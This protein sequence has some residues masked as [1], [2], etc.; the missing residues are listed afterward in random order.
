MTLLAR[1]KQKGS[2]KALL[3]ELAVIA[4]ITTLSQPL[5]VWYSSTEPSNV[6]PNNQPLLNTSWRQGREEQTK[7]TMDNW[8]RPFTCLSM[9]QI[10]QSCDHKI[11]AAFFAL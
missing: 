10:L 3:M 9:E 4:I 8:K 1:S 2:K 5:A 11:P 6:L 7:L